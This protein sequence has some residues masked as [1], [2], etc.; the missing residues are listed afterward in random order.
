MDCY[1]GET[2][3]KKIERGQIKIDEAIEIIAQVAQDYKKHTR[4]EYYSSGYKTS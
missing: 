2:L 1:E 4:K 3:K